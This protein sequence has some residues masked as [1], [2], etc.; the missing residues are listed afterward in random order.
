MLKYYVKHAST[1]DTGTEKSGY[2]GFNDYHSNK[3]DK[4]L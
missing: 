3:T 1:V 4:K 2:R